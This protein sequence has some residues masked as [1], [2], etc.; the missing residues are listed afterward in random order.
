KAAYKA[1]CQT[2]HPDKFQG[3]NEDAERIMK[4]VNASYAVL[5]DPVKRAIHDIW[6]R[7]QEAKVKQQSEKAQSGATG[8]VTEQQHNQRKD[9][10]NTQKTEEPPRSTTPKPHADPSSIKFYI[11]PQQNGINI[12]ILIAIWLAIIISSAA[13]F[14]GYKGEHDKLVLAILVLLGAGIYWLNEQK[15]YYQIPDNLKTA[16]PSFSRTA[17]SPNEAVNEQCQ[18]KKQAT[19][20]QFKQSPD[21]FWRLFFGIVAVI[22][23]MWLVLVP[24]DKSAPSVNAVTHKPSVHQAVTA[25]NQQPIPQSVPVFNQ[26]EQPLPQSGANNANF[27]DGVA[28]LKIRTSFV[29]G[30]H[31]FVKI[32]NLLNSQPIGAYFIRS[33]ETI[34]LK[35]PLGTYE[36]RYASGAKWYGLDYLFGSDTTYNKA[37]STFNFSFDGYQYS[38]YTKEL[39]MQQNGNL[40]TSA[41]MPNQW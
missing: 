20:Q 13:G 2:Y 36:I 27:R 33:G 26:P 7:E 5:I 16:E 24:D 6:I 15:H 1:L 3:S 22:W 25:T 40:R 11:K 8:K 31:Y 32:V 9:K 30:Y 12:K 21:S 35:V 37:D 38:G 4:L 14:G 10:H 23:V 41:I 34:E 39:I 18:N 19:Q 17:N 29:G 28:P